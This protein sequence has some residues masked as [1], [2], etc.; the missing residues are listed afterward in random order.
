[1][2]L[3]L[4]KNNPKRHPAT[5]C[6]SRYFAATP[7]LPSPAPKV[8]WEYKI[9]PATIGM[10]GNDQIG[11]CVAAYWVH[12]LMTITA[13]TGTTFIPD[14]AEAIAL[15]S[16]FTGYDPSQ[17]QPDGSNPTDNGGTFTDLYAYLQKTG[18]CGRKITAWAAID[19]NNPLHMAVALQIFLG[20]GV[21]VQLPMSAQTQFSAGQDWTVVPNDPIEGGHAILNSGR[22]SKGRNFAS[23]G[24]GDVKAPDPWTDTYADEAYIV[25]TPEL[26]SVAND[27]S[28]TA[29]DWDALTADMQALGS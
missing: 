21:G 23:W 7:G 6:M 11:D 4:G 20:M 14:P 26:I 27:L 12:H 16:G 13:H 25:L 18:F 19:I 2:P 24:K 5:L 22:G 8:D 15:Y 3:K 17:T 1:M 28:P 9:D 29:L 10:Y